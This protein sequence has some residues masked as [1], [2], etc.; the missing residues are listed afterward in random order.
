MLPLTWSPFWFNHDVET[1]HS[2]LIGFWVPILIKNLFDQSFQSDDHYGVVSVCVFVSLF[3]SF[4]ECFLAT[5]VRIFTRT[6]LINLTSVS[7]VAVTDRSRQAM[8]ANSDEVL[9]IIQTYITPVVFCPCNKQYFDDALCFLFDDYKFTK[10]L[11]DS[12]YLM[13]KAFTAKYMENIV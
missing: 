3:F 5:T 13:D 2:A 8:E 10:V 4:T 12:I 7:R 9:K 11:Q 1:W 6:I